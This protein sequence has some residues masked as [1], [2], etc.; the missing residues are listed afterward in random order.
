MLVWKYEYLE[1]CNVQEY[2]QYLIETGERSNILR[3][4]ISAYGIA[5]MSRRIQVLALTIEVDYWVYKLL[6]DHNFVGDIVLYFRRLVWKYKYFRTLF[7][8]QRKDVGYLDCVVIM[9]SKH[10]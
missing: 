1:H 10:T 7:E 6:T 9:F 2:E 5:M 8:N 3:I 4:G